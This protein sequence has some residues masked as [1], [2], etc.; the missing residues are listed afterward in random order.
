[1]FNH[2]VVTKQARYER[3]QNRARINA[4]IMAAGLDPV[5]FGF[6]RRSNGQSYAAPVNVMAQLS[7]G[8]AATPN[9]IWGTATISSL[10]TRSANKTRTHS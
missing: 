3:E 1:M 6:H 5:A 4:K 7:G 8:S 2:I 10:G 9:Y